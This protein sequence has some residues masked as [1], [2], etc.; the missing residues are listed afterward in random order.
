MVRVHQLIVDPKS[1]AVNQ[2]YDDQTN[3]GTSLSTG[4]QLATA[5]GIGV[6]WWLNTNF[7]LMCDFE[8]TEF[9]GGN[10]VNAA[11]QSTIP[12]EQ[13]VFSRAALL[14]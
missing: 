12:P 6:N 5:F 10:A 14:F 7:K 11:G 4:A 1:Y 9:A 8:K 3:P 2:P 13:V